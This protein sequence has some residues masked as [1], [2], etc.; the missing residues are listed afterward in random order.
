MRFLL[1]CALLVVSCGGNPGDEMIRASGSNLQVDVMATSRLLKEH[2]EVARYADSHGT[3]PLH[4]AA[5]VWNFIVVANLLAAGADPNARDKDGNT[6]L[7]LAL[8]A[9]VAQNQGASENLPGTPLTEEEKQKRS[10]IQNAVA[11]TQEQNRE[12]VVRYLVSKGGD[13]TLKNNEGKTPLEFSDQSKRAYERAV[14]ARKPM[15]R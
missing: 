5:R 11:I 2:P 4:A 15:Q 8:G 3:T 14:N 7:H 13:V 6:P 9:I 12:D 1:L 10:T